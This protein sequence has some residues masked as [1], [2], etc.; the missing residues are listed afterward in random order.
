MAGKAT[1]AQAGKVRDQVAKLTAKRSQAQARNAKA[2][3]KQHYANP[4]LDRAIA[5]VLASA[6]IPA[7]LRE[8]TKGNASPRRAWASVNGVRVERA[9]VCRKAEGDRPDNAVRALLLAYP[10]QTSAKRVGHVRAIDKA[11]AE[12]MPDHADID[13]VYLYRKA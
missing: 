7:N 2:Q 10:D 5:Q 6:L 9:K 4:E 8:A 13:A 1:K 12:A 11:T 3:G